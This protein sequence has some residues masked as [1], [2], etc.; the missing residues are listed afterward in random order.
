VEWSASGKDIGVVSGRDAVPSVVP[1]GYGGAIVVWSFENTATPLARM[2][3][4]DRNGQ[5][6]GPPTTVTTAVAPLESGLALSPPAPNPT[7]HGTAARFSIASRGRVALSVIDPSG[8]RVR[9]LRDEVL[10]PG[11]YRE[12]WRGDD[13]RGN[14]APSGLYFVVLEFD[15]RRLHRRVVLTR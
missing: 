12:V 2:T 10:E 15:G 6:Q 7:S 9:R 1:D 4:I 3:R 13:E 11:T 5:L 14:A 8:R